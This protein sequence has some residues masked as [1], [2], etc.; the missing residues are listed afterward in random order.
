MFESASIRDYKY[1]RI[2]LTSM[3][4]LRISS[5]LAGHP[6]VSPHSRDSF[7]VE[8]AIGWNIKWSKCQACGESSPPSERPHERGGRTNPRQL[9]HRSANSYLYLPI[10]HNKH[11][12]PTPQCRP[13]PP[14]RSKQQ[15]TPPQRPEK[16]RSRPPCH[17][18]GRKRSKTWTLQP[19]YRQLSKA[20]I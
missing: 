8:I 14:P 20:E 3:S 17:T 10:L 12:P 18:N 19:R 2:I 16:S 15:Q 4:I 11:T 6:T 5:H 13:H 7:S 9:I 1:P